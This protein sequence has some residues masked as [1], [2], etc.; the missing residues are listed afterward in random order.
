MSSK[1]SRIISKVLSP[2]CR[3]WLRSQVSQVDRLE[4]KIEG[5]DREILGGYIPKIAIAASAAIYQGLRV[6]Q[7]QL[8]GENI[9]IN[10][11]Q[12]L[13]GKP[14]RLLEPI[15]VTGQLWLEEAD[16]QAS[17]SAPLLSN[18]FT[19]LLA[20]L[21]AMD[22]LNNPIGNL[23]ERQIR[24]DKVTFDRNSFVLNG[25]LLPTSQLVAI[26]ADIELVSRQEIKLASIEIDISSGSDSIG[27]TLDKLQIDLG[28]QVDIKEL[29]IDCQQLVC[30][31]GVQVMP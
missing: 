26:S 15:S 17:L 27:Q 23:K 21:L 5:S 22:G 18:A 31:G 24:W 3:V 14:L 6:S 9:R 11:G 19:D 2:A 4:V 8:T 16:L 12:V 20:M 30:Q 10:L 28:S 13:K 25:S 29:K 7:V 1:S